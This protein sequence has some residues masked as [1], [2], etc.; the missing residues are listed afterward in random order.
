MAKVVWH[1]K[2]LVANPSPDPP[3]RVAAHLSSRLDV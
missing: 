3:S 2:G 1:G